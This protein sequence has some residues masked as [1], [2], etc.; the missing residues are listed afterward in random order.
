MLVNAMCIYVVDYL[1]IYQDCNERGEC[2][3][4]KYFAE[5][6]NRIYN[7]P[8]DSMKAM[9]CL[10]D[11]GWR[12]PDCSQQECPSLADPLGAYGNEQG[13]DCS[14]RGICD[15]T[16]GICKCFTGFYGEACNKQTIHF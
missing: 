7:T 2:L 8:W 9:G 14:G 15:Y 12:G 1:I 4:Q 13:R 5:K 16:R 6:S 3:P 10:C 11:P